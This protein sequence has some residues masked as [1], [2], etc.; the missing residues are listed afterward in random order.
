MKYLLLVLF[1]SSW[2]LSPAKACDYF[3]I[4]SSMPVPRKHYIFVETFRVT[5]GKEKK[6]HFE[7]HISDTRQMDLEEMFIYLMP[8]ANL[9]HALRAHANA[10]DWAILKYSTT[11]AE[12]DYNDGYI[13]QDE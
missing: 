11:V 13:T 3:R 6:I 1:V 10:D 7:T 5:C 4:G 12:D 2:L 8:T 9:K